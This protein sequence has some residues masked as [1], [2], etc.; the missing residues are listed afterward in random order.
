[1]SRIRDADAEVKLEVT[2]IPAESVP[3]LFNFPGFAESKWGREQ[4]ERRVFDSL[5]QMI[6]GLR[7]HLLDASAK[8]ITSIADAVCIRPPS[9]LLSNFLLPTDSEGYIECQVGRH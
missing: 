1:M 7:E 2:A 4:Q 3:F 9:K 5:L 6:P 8:E